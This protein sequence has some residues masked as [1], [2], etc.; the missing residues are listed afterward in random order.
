[1]VEKQSDLIK[2]SVKTRA[3]RNQAL[4]HVRRFHWKGP[5]ERQITVIAALKGC[6]SDA[7][8]QLHLVDPQHKQDTVTQVSRLRKA[9]SDRLPRYMVPNVWTVDESMPKKSSCKID[10]ARVL[11][12]IQNLNDETHL[13]IK[14]ST[15]DDDT[16]PT[17]DEDT[18]VCLQNIISQVLVIPVQKV[19]LSKSF[20][21]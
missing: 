19:P 12:W 3:G 7:Q 21:A 5:S 17:L 2:S 10:R 9:L 14:A 11:Q 6:R 4:G 8:D 18:D 1:M 13:K 20:L 15:T 16:S